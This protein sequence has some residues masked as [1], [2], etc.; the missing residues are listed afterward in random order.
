MIDVISGSSKD[1]VWVQITDT[2]VGIPQE[3]LDHVFDR[4]YRVDKARSRES[5]GTGLGL[6]IAKD[7]VQLHGGDI[8]IESTPGVGTSVTITLP[9]LPKEI[10]EDIAIDSAIN[11]TPDSEIDGATDIGDDEDEQTKEDN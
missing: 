6:A 7:I 5:G 4:F 11:S 1:T 2:G 8:N 9:L 3:D 10:E